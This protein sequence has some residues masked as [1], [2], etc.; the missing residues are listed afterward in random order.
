MP[1]SASATKARGV[2]IV[3]KLNKYSLSI[4]VANLFLDWQRSYFLTLVS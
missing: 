1:K 3:N 4:L 2:L